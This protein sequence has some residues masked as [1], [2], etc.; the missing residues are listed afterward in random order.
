MYL[1]NV[2]IS[3][4]K[5]IDV[6]ENIYDYLSKEINNKITINTSNIYN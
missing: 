4:E 6:I 3:E 5:E 2:D 1:Y